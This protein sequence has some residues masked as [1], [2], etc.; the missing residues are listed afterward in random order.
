MGKK[1]IFAGGKLGKTSKIYTSKVN[2]RPFMFETVLEEVYTPGNGYGWW[3]LHLAAAQH[4][5]ELEVDDD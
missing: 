4:W 1:D 2:G 3:A 5:S